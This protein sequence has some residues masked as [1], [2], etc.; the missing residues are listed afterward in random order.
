MTDKQINS[1]T[2]KTKWVFGA[3]DF[4]GNPKWLYLYLQKNHSELELA[5]VLDKSKDINSYKKNF[6]DIKFLELGKSSTNDYLKSAQVYVE[7]Q[8][9]EYYPNELNPEI[10]FL[11]LWH[12]VGLKEIEINIP[13]NVLLAPRIL[14]KY[15]KYSEQ[16]FNRTLFL[17]TSEAMDAHFAENILTPK[18]NFIKG[19]YPRN[20]LPPLMLDKS[21]PFKNYSK[22]IMFSPTYRDDN[23]DNFITL[24]PNLNELLNI[25]QEKNYLFIINLH[26]KM[27]NMPSYLEAKTKYS[28]SPNFKFIDETDDIYAFLNNID[29]NI[30]DYSSLFYDVILSQSKNIIRYTPDYNSYLNYQPL[31]STYYED[32]YGPVVTS[33][34]ELINL[35]KNVPN[36]TFFDENKWTEIHNKFWSYSEK[37]RIEN[38]LTT[39]DN[40][41]PTIKPLT[42]LYSYDIFDTLIRRDCGFPDGIFYLVREDMAESDLGFSYEFITRYTT[43]R[44]QAESSMRDF[45]KKTTVERNSDVLEIKFDDIFK[46]MQSTHLLTDEQ[47][48]FAKEREIYHE[49]ENVKP[50]PENIQD[51]FEQKEQ[52]NPI[53]LISDMYLPKAVIK[54]MLAKADPRLEELD[55]FLSTDE[56]YQKSTGL[57]YQKIFSES[58]LKIAQWTH[59]GDN[60][61]ADVKIPKS[62]GITCNHK[63]NAFFSQSPIEKYLIQSCPTS[64]M[65]KILNLLRHYRYKNR[66]L[67]PDYKYQKDENY[68][69]MAYVGMYLIPYV[70]SVIEKSLQNKTETLYFISRD[71]NF[72]KPIADAIIKQKQLNIKTKLI[73]ASRISL[74]EPSYYL[75]FDESAFST[76]GII[77]QSIDSL[78]K[79]LT[80]LHLTEDEFKTLFPEVYEKIE[81]KF[82]TPKL[83]Q[84]IR[85]K[86]RDSLEFQAIYREKNKDSYLKCAEYLSQEI[87]FNEN[88]SFVEFWGRGYTQARLEKIIHDKLNNKN[89]TFYYARTIYKSGFFEDNCVYDNLTSSLA[90]LT[91]IERFFAQADMTSVQGY[92]R[93][94]NKLIPIF[95]KKESEFWEKYMEIVPK[96]AEEFSMLRLKNPIMSCRVTFEKL[97]DYFHSHSKD[98]FL[99]KYFSQLSD[100]V[101]LHGTPREFAPQI[102]S[103]KLLFLPKKLILKE[104]SN[105]TMSLEKAPKNIRKIYFFRKKIINFRGIKPVKKYLKRMLLKY[106]K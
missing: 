100:N 90:S 4:V 93:L 11:N 5:W 106:A 98:P 41:I 19:A 18:E 84:I 95:E 28:Q 50:I 52:G 83:R 74:R 38:V 6:P 79:L 20:E 58:A 72:L 24:L 39:V 96:F 101:A 57:L 77:Q 36:Q 26:P 48:K 60:G 40:F 35:L 73:Y 46:I 97:V 15:L 45:Y 88:F 67:N 105:F 30:L 29:I 21:A 104:T 76:H 44:K 56:G 25:L 64:D 42:H 34:N 91:F 33:F 71:G 63:P 7:E 103:L 47:I 8:F 1:L 66:L 62:L 16:Y 22:V 23:Q 14:K 70:M 53:I 3:T 49:I 54:K 81:N 78:E 31:M 82:I 68:F 94:D 13:F 10:I 51:L 89:I 32:T 99:I 80:A 102:G 59:T 69:F 27:R 85:N 92:Q 86:M 61:H 75:G 55:I 17:S 43:I 87:N 65:S 12:G 2:N 9:R 37:H